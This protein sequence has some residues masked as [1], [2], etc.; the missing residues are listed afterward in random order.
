MRDFSEPHYERMLYDNA[1]LLSL[2]SREGDLD[3]AAGIVSFLRSTLFVEG[4]FGSAQDSESII[5][6]QPQ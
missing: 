5:E 4:G 1:G 3:S 6:G 2:Y